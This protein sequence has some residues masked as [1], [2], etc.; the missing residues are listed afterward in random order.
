[1]IS[2]ELPIPVNRQIICESKKGAKMKKIMTISIMCILFV[3]NP[4]FAD[5]LVKTF[6]GNGWKNT[7]PFKVEERWAIV[8]DSTPGSFFAVEIN[9]TD[10]KFFDGI[11]SDEARGKSYFYKGGEFYLKI[12]HYNDWK[13][14]I[15]EIE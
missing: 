1:M 12:I 10:G 13:I 3:S 2:K 7:Q 4:V 5:Y 11:N 6:S 15:Y 14:K 9:T 8:W